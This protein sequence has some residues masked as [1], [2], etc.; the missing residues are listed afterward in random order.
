MESIEVDGNCITFI[1]Y[2]SWVL[3]G[4][5]NYD[6]D[7]RAVQLLDSTRLL[8]KP[9]VRSR[10]ESEQSG[11]PILGVRVESSCEQSWSRVDSADGVK[12]NKTK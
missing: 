9:V 5:S 2:A 11:F 4:D 7:H 3:F 12:Q 6:T 1:E 10:V 8:T